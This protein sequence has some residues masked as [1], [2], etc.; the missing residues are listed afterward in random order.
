MFV[1][2]VVVVM[3]QYDHVDIPTSL[4]LGVHAVIKR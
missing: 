4:K 1:F 2:F 3:L